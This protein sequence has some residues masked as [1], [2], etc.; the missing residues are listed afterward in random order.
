M[1]KPKS[2]YLIEKRV[3]SFVQIMSLLFLLFK[4]ECNYN[5]QSIISAIPS[6][7]PFD[8]PLSNPVTSEIS[9]QLQ[10]STTR[11][12][13]E[14]LKP[15]RTEENSSPKNFFKKNVFNP[16]KKLEN[17]IQE[18]R[19]PK[20]AEHAEKTESAL[21]KG[22][23]STALQGSGAVDSSPDLPPI[24]SLDSPDL[25]VRVFT[26]GLESKALEDIQSPDSAHSALSVFGDELGDSC[27]DERTNTP[28]AGTDIRVCVSKAENSKEQVGK[29]ETGME[30]CAFWLILRR[31]FGTKVVP[32][33]VIY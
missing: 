24:V 23:Q 32:S 25:A 14:T 33:F 7:V 12:P 6:T 10:I 28:P 13:A 19:H 31:K 2:R 16:L 8:P 15:S 1:L 29:S 5:L 4:I 9:A 21:T 18:Q 20:N 11:R 3:V 26:G 27:P 22:V 17:L 30:S